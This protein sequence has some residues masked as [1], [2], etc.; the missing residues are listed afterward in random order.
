MIDRSRTTLKDI[1]K[2]D[3]L[4][5]GGT[6]VDHCLVY[7]FYSTQRIRKPSLLTFIEL[8]A[9]I[10]GKSVYVFEQHTTLAKHEHYRTYLI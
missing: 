4:N 8:E 1:S 10:I 7:V 6:T 9:K 5:H 2:A 3:K